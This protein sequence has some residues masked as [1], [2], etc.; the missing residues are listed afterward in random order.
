MHNESNESWVTIERS[1][2]LTVSKFSLNEKTNSTVFF[3][4]F[5]RN[6][7]NIF[8]KKT[9][10]LEFQHFYELL[11][12]KFIKPVIL[13]IKCFRF[14]NEI[15]IFKKIKILRYPI[16]LK[17]AGNKEKKHDKIKTCTNRCATCQKCQELSG[18]WE[19]LPKSGKL[20]NF[21]QCQEISGIFYFVSI[22]DIQCHM[23][24]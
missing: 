11:G 13:H 24:N 7:I 1:F 8:L 12:R 14:I 15:T 6:E 5:Q 22:Q 20:I 19:N 4:Y 17:F 21:L 16:F 10:D 23:F 3:L 18:I 2:M 9:F